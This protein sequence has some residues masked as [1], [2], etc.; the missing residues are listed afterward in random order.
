MPL[1]NTEIH[2]ALDSGRLIINP[3][4]I[5]RVARTETFPRQLVGL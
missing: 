2:Q 4:P 1:S 5:L 3:E